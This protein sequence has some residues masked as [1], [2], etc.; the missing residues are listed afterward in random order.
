M[1][2]KLLNEI[3]RPLR[4]QYEKGLAA[5]DRNNLDYA[6][7][8]FEPLLVREPGFFDCRQALR[9][10]Q[11]KRVGSGGGFFRKVL[12]TASNSPLL[13]KAQMALRHNPLEAIETAEKILRQDPQNQSAHRLLAEAALAVDFPRT[14]TLSLEIAHKHNP[15]D[16]PT[17]LSLCRC[18]SRLG[19]NARAEQI[20]DELAREWPADPEIYQAVKDLAANRTMQEGGYEGLAGGE[21]S[22]RDILHDKDQAISLEQEQRQVKSEDVAQKLIGEC[23]AKLAADPQ[24]MRLLRS[25]GDLHAELKQWDRALEYYERIIAV[26]GRADPSLEKLIADTRVRQ[27]DAAMETLNPDLPEQAAERQRLLAQ[28]QAYALDECRRRSERFPQDLQ[29]RFELGSLHFEAGRITEAIQEFQKAQNNPHRRLQSMSYLGQCFARR[30]M[31]DLAARSFQNALKEKL[32]FDEEKKEL[33]YLLGCALDKMGR[34]AEAIEQFK[35]I[36]EADIGYRDV[37]AR[38]DAFYAGQAGGF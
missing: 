5:L 10:T 15:R 27:L 34:P 19:Q 9:A 28:R 16:K 6:L 29:I 11:F 12:G 2:E 24:N 38:V 26:E 17:A 32:V 8:I 35:V 25:L 20:L 37:A 4:E 21:G 13:A 1:P 3:D 36:Y 14:A 7:A 23:E 31:H 18:L 30:G 22:Y 33:I